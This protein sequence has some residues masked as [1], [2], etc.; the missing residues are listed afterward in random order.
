MGNEATR[1]IGIPAVPPKRSPETAGGNAPAG[2]NTNRNQNPRAAAPAAGRTPAAPAGRTPETGRKAEAQKA[3]SGVLDVKEQLPTPEQPK[4][5]TR[6]KRQKKSEQGN[7]TAEQVSALIVALSAIAASRPGLEMMLISKTE[8]DTI[9][10]PLCNIIAKSERFKDL[11][12]HTDA[13]A[14]VTAC[15][16]VFA[17]R[18]IL[19]A[20]AAKEKKAREKAG[21]KIV[22]QEKPVDAGNGNESRKAAPH[23]EDNGYGAITAIPC[24]I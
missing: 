5:K 16:V 15:L 21:V 3:R 6:A 7:F 8:A 12:E 10:T 4:K 11:G 9:A 23:A 22:R 14:L 20:N 2:G 17:P 1:D 24:I 19:L 13:I 18:I